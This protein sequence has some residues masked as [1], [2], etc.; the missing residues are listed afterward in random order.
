MQPLPSFTLST[1]ATYVKSDV[2]DIAGLIHDLAALVLPCYVLRPALV[3]TCV[4][5]T[6]IVM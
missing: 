1:D 3:V 6:S 5:A 4:V 2:A